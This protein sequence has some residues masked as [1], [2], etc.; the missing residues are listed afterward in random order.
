M[1]KF[2]VEDICL[3]TKYLSSHFGESILQLG[4]ISYVETSL[5][6]NNDYIIGKYLK[7]D[8]KIITSM[9]SLEE[10]DIPDDL[11]NRQ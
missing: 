2:L 8:H 11:P 4:G 9:S 3:G 6:Y 5:E 1:N 7:K 10:Y